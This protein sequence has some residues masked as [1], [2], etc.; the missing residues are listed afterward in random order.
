MKEVEIEPSYPTT[1]TPTS[2]ATNYSTSFESTTAMT[3]E[4]N[5]TTPTATPTLLVPSLHPID[6]ASSLIPTHHL[7]TKPSAGP[8]QPPSVAPSPL[9]TTFEPTIA[10][11]EVVDRPSLRPSTSP[12]S[13]TQNGL[14]VIM[15]SPS[16]AT[17]LSSK[18][19]LRNEPTSSSLESDLVFSSGNSEGDLPNVNGNSEPNAGVGIGMGLLVVTPLVI[20]VVG[21]IYEIKR[22]K[23]RR[24]R[25]KTILPLRS[26]PTP[27]DLVM[28]HTRQNATSIQDRQI[29]GSDLITRL[30]DKATKAVICERSAKSTHAIKETKEAT[31]DV[32]TSQ[33]IRP[34]IRA[35]VPITS[36]TS[37]SDAKETQDVASRVGMSESLK[38]EM[39]I[40]DTSAPNMSTTSA[41]DAED[42]HKDVCRVGISESL[43]KE[44]STKDTRAVKEMKNVTSGALFQNTQI[45]ASAPTTSIESAGAVKRKKAATDSG[46]ASNLKK[47]IVVKDARKQAITAVAATFSDEMSVSSSISTKSSGSIQ[48]MTRFVIKSMKNLSA[49][50]KRESTT[51]ATNQED[52]ATRQFTQI[53]QS[54]QEESFTIET[55][56]IGESRPKSEISAKHANAE[57]VTREEGEYTLDTRSSS[58]TQSSESIQSMTRFAISSTESV[59]ETTAKNKADDRGVGRTDDANMENSTN[60]SRIVKKDDAVTFFEMLSTL[61]HYFDCNVDISA[62][63]SPRTPS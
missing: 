50:E 54:T 61:Q 19:T 22:R 60:S 7:T 30:A 45:V 52:H 56:T 12:S 26:T 55:S 51:D 27:K 28:T 35:S 8:S 41:S 10:K 3:N 31:A 53:I 5:T 24:N 20:L 11:V 43:K 9:I 58:S 59:V 1:L 49:N 18:P 57:K 63:N 17:L 44:M 34:Q 47:E 14:A 29:I 25:K 13:S 4:Y 15:T 46:V 2:S 33:N 16:S 40:K 32:A 38:R 37:A 36:T 6:L 48:S 23:R 39:S 42:T 21:I 62:G